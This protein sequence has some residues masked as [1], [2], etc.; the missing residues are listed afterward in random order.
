M[1]NDPKFT[2]KEFDE[3]LRKL[4]EAKHLESPSHHFKEDVMTKVRIE[5]KMQT[6]RP[7]ISRMGWVIVSFFILAVVVFA[8]LSPSSSTTTPAWISNATGFF[9]SGK[10]DIPFLGTINSFLNEFHASGLLLPLTGL[11]LAMGFHGLVMKRFYFPGKKK[12]SET[13]L[14]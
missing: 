7:V 2:E 5:A 1:N 10:L 14:F 11:L 13:F 6:Y 3:T 8:V 4:F 12:I 9:S